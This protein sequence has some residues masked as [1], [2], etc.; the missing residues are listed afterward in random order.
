VSERWELA[1]RIVPPELCLKN[2]PA[3]GTTPIPIQVQPE[4]KG[5]LRPSERSLFAEIDGSVVLFDLETGQGFSLAGIGSD[6]W[7][8]IV[9]LGDL[10]AVI[11]ELGRAYDAPE[12]ILR[13]DA[14]RFT[15]DLLARGLLNRD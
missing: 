14:E 13:A 9:R 1:W 2:R 8:S 15:D 10:E 4:G 7:R 11:A 6:L 5:P 3:P 12:A